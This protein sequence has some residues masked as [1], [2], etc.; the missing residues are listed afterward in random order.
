MAREQGC[1]MTHLFYSL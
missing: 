1:L